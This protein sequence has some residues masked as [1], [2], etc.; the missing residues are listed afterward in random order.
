MA[1]TKKAGRQE[2]ISAA[3][4][5]AV[6]DMGAMN[7]N[8]V[9]AI[10]LPEGAVLLSGVVII[11]TAF[12]G[13]TS[14]TLTVGDVADPDR[15]VAGVDAQ[16]EALTALVPTG[17]ELTTPTDITIAI[18]NVGGVATAGAGRLIVEYVVNGRSAFSQG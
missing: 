18:T 10:E 6:A 14:D 3:V 12:D 11:D 16:A 15:Y 8:D 7:G 1:I 5:F 17:L 2:V 9:A 13:T 4:A